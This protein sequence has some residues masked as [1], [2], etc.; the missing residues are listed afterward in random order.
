MNELSEDRGSILT[1]RAEKYFQIFGKVGLIGDK[2]ECFF[3]LSYFLRVLYNIS[4]SRIVYM[5]I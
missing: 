4:T 5:K 3:V 2:F 1:A